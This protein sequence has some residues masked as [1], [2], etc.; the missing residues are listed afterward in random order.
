METT[1]R[2][3]KTNLHAPL[4]ISKVLMVPHQVFLVPWI[5]LHPLI[6][7][8]TL[9][10]SLTE[11]VKVRHIGELRVVELGHERASGGCVVYLCLFLV[12]IT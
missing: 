11:A 9:E 8:N 6:V 5:L 12:S 1:P 10:H 7:L 4:R 3:E 2:N